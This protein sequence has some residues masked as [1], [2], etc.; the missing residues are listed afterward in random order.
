MTITDILEPTPG[1]RIE[2]KLDKFNENINK[3]FTAVIVVLTIGFV[4]LLIAVIDPIINA[5]VFKASTYQNLVDKI[6]RQ[7]IQINNINEMLLKNK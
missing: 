7:N 6:D 2:N 1:E 5:M 4:T 3:I